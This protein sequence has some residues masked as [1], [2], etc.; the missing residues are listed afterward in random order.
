MIQ[1]EVAVCRETCD[2][3]LGFCDIVCGYVDNVVEAIAN[4]IV[5][6]FTNFKN[7]VTA[8]VAEIESAVNTAITE[9]K[10]YVDYASNLFNE[11]KAGAPSTTAALLDSAGTSIMDA[12][13]VGMEAVVTALAYTPL[14]LY[15][16]IMAWISGIGFAG[17][18]MSVG[19]GWGPLTASMGLSYVGETADPTDRKAL[20]MEICVGYITIPSPDPDIGV[21]VGYVITF[22]STMTFEDSKMLGSN[23]AA[24]VDLGQKYTIS[25]NIVAYFGVPIDIGGS[26]G[27]SLVDG[28]NNFLNPFATVPNAVSCSSLSPVIKRKSTTATLWCESSCCFHLQCVTV[29]LFILSNRA[30]LAFIAESF[31]LITIISIK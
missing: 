18:S 1:D 22:D 4:D 29:S 20:V 7:D 31:M 28:N 16:S 15:P 12:L 23:V 13:S 2:T 24:G 27:W 8:L 30:I 11:F 19:F 26:V 14:G 9:A 17:I 5:Q 3:D 6:E 25:T 10:K 21:E